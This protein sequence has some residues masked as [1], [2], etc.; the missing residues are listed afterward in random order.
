MRV[1]VDYQRSVSDDD[2]PPLVYQWCRVGIVCDSNI[3]DVKYLLEV[4]PDGIEENEL[5]SRL[6]IMKK[7]GKT[8]GY[9]PLARKNKLSGD[10]LQR[11]D[12][13]RSE[14]KYKTWDEI[15]K[16]E[17]EGAKHKEALKIVTRATM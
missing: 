7:E 6:L 2:D 10:V 8:I 13:I 16:F 15:F 11:L 5:F 14:L 12:F 17:R 3:P 1:K 4:T 9:K